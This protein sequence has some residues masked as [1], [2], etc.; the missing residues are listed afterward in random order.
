ML[1]NEF[2]ARLIM[3]DSNQSKF[4]HRTG[5]SLRTVNRWCNETII[6][7]I[8]VLA[9]QALESQHKEGDQQ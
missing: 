1:A 2:K 6:P 7:E 3:I 9:L 8:A 4:A 5:V